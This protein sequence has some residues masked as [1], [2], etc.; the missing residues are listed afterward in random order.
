MNEQ[1]CIDWINSL[2]IP[3]SIF[4]DKIEDL[5]SNSHIILNIISK[6]LNKRIEELPNIIN[7]S[8]SLNSLKNI[9][10]L[11]NLYFDYNYDYL[12]KENLKKNTI[13]MIIFLK[14]RYPKEKKTHENYYQYYN[15]NSYIDRQNNYNENKSIKLE[16]KNQINKEE[17]EKKRNLV[18]N[19]NI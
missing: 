11:L 19:N 18:C 4:I 13:A 17:K 14:A 12:N 8:N 2:D 3:E 7:N 5:Y 1:Y 9:E 6:I 15:H 10:F 16:N